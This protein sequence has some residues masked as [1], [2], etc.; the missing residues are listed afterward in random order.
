[1]A[2]GNVGHTAVRNNLVKSTSVV[3]GLLTS[4]CWK[5][6][7]SGLFAAG[8]A[9]GGTGQKEEWKASGNSIKSDR[10]FADGTE[11]EER[12]LNLLG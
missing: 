6:L 5:S 1:M 12:Q 3:T 4:A 2:L 8:S 7:I 10:K 11:L 9:W